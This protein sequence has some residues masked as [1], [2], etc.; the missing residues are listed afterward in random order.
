MFPTTRTI[1]S[2]LL[3]AMAVPAF[4]A[5]PKA[6]DEAAI[7]KLIDQLGDDDFDKRET[8]AKR[9]E[10]IGIAALPLLRKTVAESKDAEQ[11]ARADELAA[12]IA[13]SAFV[14]VRVF[15]KPN[16]RGP[17]RWI[18]RVVVT[19]DGKQ[20]ITGG[21][22]CL[23]VWDIAT[24]K[25]VRTFGKTEK[26]YWALLCRATAS[27]CSLPATAAWPRCGMWKRGRRSSN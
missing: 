14:Q 11:R 2:I 9:L 13:K 24:G 23:I 22:E 16:L 26:A 19:P 18:S 8:A 20:A 27:G 17:R 6:P 1:V 21:D 4:A 10:A 12:K 5:D 15:D 3:V 25:V 7:R